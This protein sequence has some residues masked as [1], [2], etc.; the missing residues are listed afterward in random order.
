[1][2]QPGARAAL[3]T[4]GMAAALACAIQAEAKAPTKLDACRCWDV[5]YAGND[6]SDR[7]LIKEWRQIRKRDCNQAQQHDPDEG[8]HHSLHGDCRQGWLRSLPDKLQPDQII[9]RWASSRAAHHV[10]R[11]EGRRLVRETTITPWKRM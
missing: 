3:G 2:R 5:D 4:A 8:G 1:M 6:L 9:P 7:E 10:G 11:T